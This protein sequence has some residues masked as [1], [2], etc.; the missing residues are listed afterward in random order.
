MPAVWPGGKLIQRKSNGRNCINISVGTAAGRFPVLV[1]Q[2]SSAL[3]PVMA[4]PEGR[5][6]IRE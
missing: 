4:M 5:R 1:L 3:V 6:D 2:A